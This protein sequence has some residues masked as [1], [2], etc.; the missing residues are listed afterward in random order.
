MGAMVRGGGPALAGGWFG[1][2]VA[3]LYATLL[4]EAAAASIAPASENHAFWKRL[5]GLGCAAVVAAAGLCCSA[6][7]FVAVAP[8][9]GLPVLVLAVGALCER[10]V[11]FRRMHAAFARGGPLGRAAA[12][13]LT[14]G[15]ATGLVFLTLAGSLVATGFLVAAWPNNSWVAACASLTA[16]AIVFPLPLLLFLPRLKERATLYVAVQAICLVV[17]GI[18]AAMITTPYGRGS[19]SALLAPFPLA[20]LLRL[21]GERNSAAMSVL[22]V[23]GLVVDRNDLRVAVD[24]QCD[25]EQIAGLGT[26]IHECGVQL[27]T[28][29]QDR[30]VDH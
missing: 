13:M 3:A 22:G 10:P 2:V 12:A 25:S 20:G 17:F 4:L 28:G 19:W 16:A 27:G 6:R 18:D 29:R 14:P 15:W 9:F 5:M 21:I 24:Q 26:L 1:C 7:D 23:A 30:R 11:R 8:V